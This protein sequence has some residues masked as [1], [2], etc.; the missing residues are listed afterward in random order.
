MFARSKGLSLT[1][2]AL[3]LGTI[4]LATAGDIPNMTPSER[5]LMAQHPHA[6]S[7]SLQSLGPQHYIAPGIDC[8]ESVSPRPDH[9]L[10]G[11]LEIRD[12][13]LGSRSGMQR[14]DMG[15]MINGGF[16]GGDFT[17]WT[18]SGAAGTGVAS[19]CGDP[20]PPEAQIVSPTLQHFAFFDP[21]I[22]K[23]FQGQYA[24]QL[25]DSIP[26]GT[27]PSTEPQC[28]DVSQDVV[29]PTGTANFN[30]AY[31]VLASNPGHGYLYDPYFDVKVEDLT[32][33]TILYDVI[34]YTTSYNP[35]DP[36]N[37]WCG[38]D[39]DPIGLANCVYR[40]WTT[41][42]LDLSSIAG[43]TV[44]VSLKSS[45]CSPSAH[46][47][48]AFLD[49]AG[50]ACP[51]SI[52]PNTAPITATCRPDTLGFCAE[53][54]WI[55]PG[56]TSSVPDSLGQN[57][58][59]VVQAAASY[60][61]RWSTS[62]IVTETDY[63]NASLVSGEPA[64]SAPGT[65]E[66]FTFCGLPAGTIYV[67]LKSVDGTFNASGMTA[68]A[69][70]CTLNNPP[71]CSQAVSSLSEL[72]PPN[73]QFVPV[74]I[75]GVTDP[76]GDP[77]TIVI[78]SVTQD[79][80]TNTT[81]DGNTCPD[82]QIVEGQCQLRAERTGDPHVP[83]N[84]R[85]YAVNFTASD[86]MGASCSGIV[87]VCVP[88]DQSP[89]HECF[90]DG[91][92]VNSLICDDGQ[93]P[94]Q[95]ADTPVGPPSLDRAYLYPIGLSSGATSLRYYLP[96]EGN[97]QLS[98]FDLAG[99]RVAT[100]EDGSRAAGFHQTTWVTKDVPAGIYFVR[101]IAAGDRLIRRCVIVR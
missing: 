64:P 54:H 88:H 78:D 28:S 68:T 69:I 77:I 98:V 35:S 87:Y 58:I 80:P 11:R 36:C 38:G 24:A 61:I 52:A 85:V 66:T 73:H 95:S 4:S 83:G 1:L 96:R 65:P 22:N 6:E 3:L 26:W 59:P 100:L 7:G 45:D 62:P 97:V 43:H 99:R 30:F 41:V 72:W 15:P 90:D 14:P 2:L 40:C 56:D 93:I 47:C 82:A 84:G 81:G 34:D 76:D 70:N 39:F 29:I 60:D 42:T 46:F 32:T 5:S 74:S 71:D 25:G 89:H 53:L 48:E 51:D 21:C 12:F 79:E 55:A 44:R 23:V 92:Y 75:L 9:Q 86:I 63:D 18:I 8:R 57:C 17:G 31:A 20:M 91:Q 67:A 37:P 13:L 19:V 50:I 10:G 27:D 101:A 16:E 94:Y 33:S 49:G